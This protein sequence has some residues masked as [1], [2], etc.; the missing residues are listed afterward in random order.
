MS[1]NPLNDGAV[2]DARL[3]GNP[4]ML[5]LGLQHMFAMFALRYLFRP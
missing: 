2:Y 3:L 1:N 4:K 5:A